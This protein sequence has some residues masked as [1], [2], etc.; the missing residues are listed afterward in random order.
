M[1]VLWVF[2]SEFEESKKKKKTILIKIHKL[3]NNR[4]NRGII[5]GKLKIILFDS[6]DLKRKKRGI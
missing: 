5:V 3:A 2:R 4:I 6:I 1:K